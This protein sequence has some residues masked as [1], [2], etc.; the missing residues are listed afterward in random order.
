MTIFWS[1]DAWLREFD[2]SGAHSNAKTAPLK[3]SCSLL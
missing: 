1:D 3:N 2:L